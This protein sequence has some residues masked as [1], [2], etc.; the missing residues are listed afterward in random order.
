[1]RHRARYLAAFVVA[2]VVAAACNDDDFT[3]IVPTNATVHIE[4]Q[5]DSASFN[6]A[7]GAG[8]CKKA[9]GVTFTAFNAEL[10]ATQRVAT[11]RFVPTEIGVRRG[12]A[13]TATN[14]GGEEH[15]FTE[16]ESFGGGIVPALNTASGN[17]TITPECARLAS[18]D[19][20]A[21]GGTFTT[22]AAN[23]IGTEHYQCCIHPWMRATVTVTP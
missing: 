2:G 14:F 9:G 7:L 19:H 6:A 11:W 8:T 1:M 21:P 10:D 20:V 18:T 13:I 15:T 22:D 4:D 23:T 17:L 5:C 12:Q 16:V 3:N